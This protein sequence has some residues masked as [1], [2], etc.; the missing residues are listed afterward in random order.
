M[1]A[2]RSS[3]NYFRKVTIPNQKPYCNF[4]IKDDIPFLDASW[5]ILMECQMI[6]FLDSKSK[7]FSNISFVRGKM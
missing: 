3:L 5:V 2:F 6:Q 1:K 7:S 4:M